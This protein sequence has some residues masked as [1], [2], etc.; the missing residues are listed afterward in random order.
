MAYFNFR[1]QIALTEQS[2]IEQIKGDN[3]KFWS[4]FTDLLCSRNIINA[5]ISLYA[6]NLV[7]RFKLKEF[8]ELFQ[9]MLYVPRIHL[10]H[11]KTNYAL[12]PHTDNE[13]KVIVILIY[14]E[15]SELQSAYAINLKT[16]ETYSMCYSILTKC[17]STGTYS[18]DA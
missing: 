8:N 6:H 2:E 7:K 14:F 5:F 3:F 9:K 16:L 10:I 1:H 15:F 11:D 18:E 4:S 17:L 13:G 12:G